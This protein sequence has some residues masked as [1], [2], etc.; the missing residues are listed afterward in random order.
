M[1]S[2][3]FL[4]VDGGAT[5]SNAILLDSARRVRAE[6]TGK[7]SNFQIIGIEQASTN[8]LE[9]AETT[10]KKSNSDF[11]QVKSIC[12]ALAG[13][14]RKDDADKMRNE[15]VALLEA[16][17]YFA[18]KVRVE[19]DA[20]AALEGALG[21]KGGMV[22]IAGTGSIL[23]AKDDRRTIHRTGGWG[24]FI[25]DEGSGYAMGRSCLEA[26]AREF[27]GRGKKTVMTRLLKDRT[28]IEG[29]DSLVR[30]VYQNNFD[31]ASVAPLVAEAAEMGDEAALEIVR[32]NIDELMIHIAAIL[33]KLNNPLPLVL[34]GTLLSSENFFSRSVHKR[35]SRQF[36]KIEIRKPEY[37]P[38][39]G[40]A[41]LALES[42]EVRE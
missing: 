34:L 22:L 23:L 4:G 2:P 8:I 11:S 15:F 9:T 41:L 36:P 6:G 32:E 20:T 31:I 42:G 29:P 1:D 5:K 28:G 30:E 39:V 33:R 17:K 40:A 24:R 14:G 12:L 38:A 27:D 13:A 18:P 16:K 10:L 19:S 26:V 25:G 21:G 3:L 35:I 37:S 7:P